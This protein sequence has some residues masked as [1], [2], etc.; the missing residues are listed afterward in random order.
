MITLSSGS[1]IRG[2]AATASVHIIITGMEQDSEGVGTSKILHMGL[3]PITLTTLY[4]PPSGGQTLVDSIYLFNAG[5]APETGLMLYVGSYRIPCPAY[6]NVNYSL[7]VG[8]QDV[9]LIT[10]T[11]PYVASGGGG[12]SDHSML[13]NLDYAA[14]GHTGFEATTNKSTDATLGGATPSDTLYPSQKAVKSYIDEA[15]RVGGLIGIWP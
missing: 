7:I 4:T 14:A 5:A 3:L 13:S 11:A 1:E 8:R 15:A 12:T 9:Q 6:L 2:V 10:P